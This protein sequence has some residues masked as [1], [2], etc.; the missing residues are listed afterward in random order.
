MRMQALTGSTLADSAAQAVIALAAAPHLGLLDA[1][2]T[3]RA[4]AVLS[5]VLMAAMGAGFVD[6]DLVLLLAERRRLT[7]VMEDLAADVVARIGG[8]EEFFA[9]LELS[10]TLAD[11]I[12]LEQ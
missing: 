2:E 6:A 5:T 1:E 9:L 12:G 11:W 10:T 7:G 8:P 4:A 3:A